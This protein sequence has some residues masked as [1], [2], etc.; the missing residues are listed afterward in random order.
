MAVLRSMERDGVEDAR[1]ILEG[2]KGEHDIS[3][4]IGSSGSVKRSKSGSNS[5]SKAGKEEAS[6]GRRSRDEK[7]IL[8]SRGSSDSVASSS[9]KKSRGRR[10]GNDKKAASAAPAGKEGDGERRLTLPL[11]EDPNYRCVHFILGC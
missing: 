11:C 7:D 2:L 1:G 6:P 8:Q 10:S 5:S 9:S 4:D 3:A